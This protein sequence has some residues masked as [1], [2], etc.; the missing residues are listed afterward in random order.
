MKKKPRVVPPWD[1]Y[2]M[3]LAFFVASRSKD[4]DT[5]HGAI[6]VHE[7]SHMPVGW[8]YNG[9]PKSVIDTELDWSRPHKY[10]FIIHAE[11]N[12]IDNNFNKADFDETILYVTGPPCSKCMIQLAKKKI[13]KVIY[14]PQ[15]S[16]MVDE[17][18]W[19]D[20][21]EIAKLSRLTVERFQGN[22]NWMRDR[23]RWMVENQAEVF[24]PIVNMP[25]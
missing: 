3:A 16:N 11:M 25:L 20:S 8:G 7:N 9:P 15:S 4:P 12:A 1:D 2:F 14:G 21:K 23:M 13:K 17:K 10:P 6:L 5:Q 22:L 24:Q 18:D 19:R